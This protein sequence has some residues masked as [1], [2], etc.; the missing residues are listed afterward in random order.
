MRLLRTFDHMLAEPIFFYFGLSLMLLHEM[1]AIRCQEWR[2]FPLTF[3]LSDRV[4]YAV[5]V[6]AHIPLYAALLWGLVGPGREGLITALDHF[7]WIHLLA[8][9]LYL[10]HPKNQ[11][12]DWLSWGIIVGAALCGVADLWL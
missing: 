12:K 8:H 4:G 11:F 3:F 2:I 10:R 7:F 1:D 9:L 6:L 5:F